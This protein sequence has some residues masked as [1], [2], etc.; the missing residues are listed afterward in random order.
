MR[1]Y[2]GVQ[3]E[4]PQ[5]ISVLPSYRRYRSLGTISRDKQMIV[6]SLIFVLSFASMIQFAKLSWRAGLLRIEPMQLLI[7]S[8]VHS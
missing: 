6:S 4:N 3:G 7:L 5:F 2:R 1:G 8:L